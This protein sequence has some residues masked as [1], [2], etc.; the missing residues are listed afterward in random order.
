MGRIGYPRG[1]SFGQTSFREP[2]R[3]SGLNVKILSVPW[4]AFVS[5]Y[6]VYTH[7]YVRT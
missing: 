6:T 7:T 2:L 1:I 3:G 5:L 4:D